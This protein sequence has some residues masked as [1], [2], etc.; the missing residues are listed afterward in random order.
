MTLG[1]LNRVDHEHGD[2]HGADAAGDGSDD[3]SLLLHAV[4]VDVADEAIAA[5]LRGVFDTVDADVDNR[6]AV[7]DHVGRDGV[8]PS[9]GNNEDVGLAR[10]RGHVLRAGM[11]DRDGGVGVLLLLEQHV[12]N[13]FADDIAASHHDGV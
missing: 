4:E 1:G 5:L 7:L 3:G 2:G 10:E 12:G 9:G 6:G 11:A 8:G 13:R